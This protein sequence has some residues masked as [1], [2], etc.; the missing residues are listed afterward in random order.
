[1]APNLATHSQQLTSFEE[2]MVD[3]G[4]DEIHNELHSGRVQRVE[5]RLRAMP[6]LVHLRDFQGN[7]L[8]HNACWA[9][10]PAMVAV[11]LAFNPD[12][13][14]KGLWGAT[15]LY[16]AIKDGGPLTLPIVQSLLSVGADPNIKDDGGLTPIDMAKVEY[17]DGIDD[18][19][20]LL[21]NY[22]R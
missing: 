2:I 9:K 18:V 14:A 10:L 1:L 3:D 19:I 17:F 15:P 4:D 20:A 6:D 21:L 13:N 5:R 8:L 22:R 11:L 12:V 7:T 16:F